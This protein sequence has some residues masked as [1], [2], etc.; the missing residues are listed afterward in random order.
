MLIMIGGDFSDEEVLAILQKIRDIEQAKPD[1]E[2]QIRVLAG[3]RELTRERARALLERVRPPLGRLDEL[4]ER[5][6]VHPPTPFS[7]N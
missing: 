7:S 3:G 5:M 1:R 2:I 6:V 4:V